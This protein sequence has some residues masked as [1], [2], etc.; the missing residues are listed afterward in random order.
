MIIPLIFTIILTLGF[1]TPSLNLFSCFFGSI[2]VKYLI[3]NFWCMLQLKVKFLAS[4]EIQP[5][6]QLLGYQVCFIYSVCRGNNVP[7]EN[8]S[9][10]PIQ[11]PSSIPSPNASPLLCCSWNCK[12]NDNDLQISHFPRHSSNYCLCTFTFK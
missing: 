12:T 3:H 7:Q 11:S 1:L 9:P 4:L 8:F 10:M 2:K 6:A 5:L